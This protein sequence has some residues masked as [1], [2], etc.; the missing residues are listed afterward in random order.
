MFRASQIASEET[1]PALG[2]LTLKD[3]ESE[4][5]KLTSLKSKQGN[6]KTEGYGL[7]TQLTPRG[8][9]YPRAIIFVLMAKLFEAFAANGIRTILAL[10]LRDDLYFSESL[11]TI[12]LHIFNFFGQFCPIFGAILADS[13]IGNV[14]TITGFYFLYAFGWIL[15]V[16]TAL[17]YMGISLV[18]LVSISLLFIAIG[19][20]SSRACLTSLGAIQFQLPQQAK[21]LAEYFS[22]YYFVYYVGIFLS[23]IL[24]PMVRAN[25]TCFNKSG[26]YPAVFGTLG[27]SFFVA[28][29]TFCIGKLY[30]KEEKLSAENILLKF[31]GC[32]KHA[33][34]R[35]WSKNADVVKRSYWLHYAVGKYE[36]SFVNDVAKVLKLAKLF[37]PLPIYFALL[38]QQDSSWTFQASQMNTTIVPGVTIQPDQA[39][40][41][42][43]IFLFIL[44][45][46]WQYLMKPCLKCCFNYE[47]QPLQSVTLGGVFSAFSFIC[48][49]VLQRYILSMPYKSVNVLWQIP[50]FVLIMLGELLLSI[51]GLQFAF[52][53]APASM[54]SVVTAAWFLNN[55]FGNLIV[56]L[57]T[58]L[59]IFPTQSDEFF[60]YAIL[61]IVAIVI[62]TFLAYDYALQ[63]RLG[64]HYASQSSLEMSENTPLYNVRDEAPSTSN[65]NE[66]VVDF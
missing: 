60:F 30:Y 17:P 22:L 23:K 18:F 24:P 20:G 19:N 37:L 21:Q 47:L 14:R 35:K 56:V 27:T 34:A 12:V 26:C 2:V 53:Q 59:N 13:Y 39:K 45:P 66:Q 46:L 49:G 57:I 4:I 32:I 55:A 16:L 11:S 36:D 31:Y 29:L 38:A 64:H 1:L 41:M 7:V 15:L 8:I 51:P 62:Y 5:S 52:T 48:A 58:E 63:E 33:L 42:G 43:P 44:I 40:A 9:R 28:W 10:Y 50:Q 54:K 3:N 25:T 65:T 6:I 61:M